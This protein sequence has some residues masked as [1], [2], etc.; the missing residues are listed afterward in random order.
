MSEAGSVLNAYCTGNNFRN[1]R[2][3][4]ASR[5]IGLSSKNNHANY[6]FGDALQKYFGCKTDTMQ[7]CKRSI[8]SSQF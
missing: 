8:Y 3:W 1:N 4:K 7:A 5:I 2:K 6:N